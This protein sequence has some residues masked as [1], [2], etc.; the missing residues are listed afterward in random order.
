MIADGRSVSEDETVETDVCIVGGGVAGI[1]LA[2]EFLGQGFEVLLL[3]SGDL[4]RDDKT[5][6]LYKGDNIG[7]PYYALDEA[8][9]RFLGGSANY[10]DTDL[11]NHR[12][13]VRLRPLDPIDFE[14]RD[15]VPYSGW[16]FD[17][18]H[19]DPFYA[20]AQVPFK[21]APPTYDV[22]A[23]E[24]SRSAPRLPFVGND[25]ETVI[26]K[27]GAQDVFLGE[28]RNQIARS[29]DNVNVL[30]FSNVVAIETNAAATVVERLRVASLGGNR[31]WV[32]AKIV[33]L[34]AGGIEVPRLL[35]LSDSVQRSGLG[36]QNDL[37]GRFF[38][39]HLH[40]WSGVYLPSQ[41]R[42][43]DSMAAL[44]RDIHAVNSVL[45][46]GKLALT[47]STLRREKLLNQ[48]I[49][50][51][52]AEISRADLFPRVVSKS[53]SSLRVLRTAIADRS[54][55][56]HLAQ[57]LGN[58]VIG[59]DDIARYLY[60]RV[61]RE[62]AERTSNVSIRAF[63]L[64]HMTEQLPNPDSRVT[65]GTQ[66]DA[67]G[68][69]RVRLDWRLRPMD[70]T[71][72]VR[73]QAIIDSALRRAGLGRLY[74]ETRDETP[75]CGD[76]PWGVHGGYHHMGTTRMHVDARKGVVDPDCRV[77]GTANLFI[78]GPSLFPTVG[79]ANPVLTTVALA[80]RLA[81]H[82]KATLR[83]GVF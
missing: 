48:N 31:F 43:L 42:S 79:Y 53:I 2:Q 55:P 75:P 67:L 69:Q 41:S 1:T 66:R 29:T 4:A 14:E 25:V 6:S 13:G 80:M 57:H 77:H 21:T 73:T 81:D 26:F 20:R 56:N 11:G 17:R 33:I 9:A 45:V 70:L 46:V 34:A 8:R 65:L 19:L 32:T 5:Q 50:L 64:A 36:N 49:Q 54:A 63:R 18:S 58:I 62:F 38:M 68:Q 22:A 47:E 39:E 51:M 15:W 27:F 30:V 35:L 28:Y 61:R 40:F 74:T 60:R 37:V 16:P 78:A 72:V 3:E 12:P 7:Y 82:V 59:A 24:D 44:Y 83:R 71:S 10:W 23:W 76:V 52:P